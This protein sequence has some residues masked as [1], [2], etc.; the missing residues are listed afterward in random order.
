E[1]SEEWALASSSLKLLEEE[2]ASS[3]SLKQSKSWPS[4]SSC[5]AQLVA[6]WQRR[7]S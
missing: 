2:P 5:W 1:R 7:A 6:Y 4:T 3:S